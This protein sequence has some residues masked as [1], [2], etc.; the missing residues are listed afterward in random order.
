M[1]GTPDGHEAGARS[2]LLGLFQGGQP[3]LNLSHFEHPYMTRDQAHSSAASPGDKVPAA[4]ASRIADDATAKSLTV[5]SGV[6]T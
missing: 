2:W 1:Y 4:Q 3:C 6:R 5:S